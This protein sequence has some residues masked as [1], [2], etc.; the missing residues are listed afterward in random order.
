MGKEEALDDASALPPSSPL[1]R[2]VLVD[3]REDA[4]DEAR[5]PDCVT[6]TGQ[7]KTRKRVQ[8]S[9]G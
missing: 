2:L 1:S 8:S 3:S 4:S 5:A 6:K 7:E 9:G